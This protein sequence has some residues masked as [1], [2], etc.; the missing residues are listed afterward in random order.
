MVLRGRPHA[1]DGPGLA[2]VL[3]ER[4]L[5]LR[6]AR[7]A[8]TRLFDDGLAVAV[9]PRLDD[10]DRLRHDLGQLEVA[11]SAYGPPA[12]VDVRRLREGQGLTQEEFAAAFGLD[13]STLRNW[14]QGRSE[15]DRASRSLLRTI[16]A[17]PAAVREAL[18][19]GTD[20]VLS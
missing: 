10:W 6:A 13:L 2:L 8:A 17:N 20:S 5:S 3:A 7:L 15:P 1:V 4:G 16:A 18:A 9:L 12:R 11:V 14:E 19:E